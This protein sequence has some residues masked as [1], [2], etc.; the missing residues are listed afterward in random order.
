M[1]LN[2]FKRS[3]IVFIP[4][5]LPG[6]LIFIAGIVYSVYSF[7]DIDRRSH[8]ASDTLMNFAF[9]LLIIGIV[10]SLIAYLTVR[11]DE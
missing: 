4:V 2:W 8:S 3:G 5:S 1:K 7:I 9:M 6:W 11:K 10:Y